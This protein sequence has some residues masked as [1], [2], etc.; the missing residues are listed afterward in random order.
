MRSAMR[1][2]EKRCEIRIAIFPSVS[3]LKLLEDFVF[4]ARVDRCGR[5]IEHQ[6]LGIAHEGAGQ[7]DLLPLAEESSWPS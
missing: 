5:F 1:T 6:I 2:V 4:G 7:R 3:A